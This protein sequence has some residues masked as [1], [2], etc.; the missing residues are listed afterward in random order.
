MGIDVK[1][2]SMG[3]K[4]NVKV[5][6]DDSCAKVGGKGAV[7]I[8]GEDGAIFMP[9]VS[10]DGTLTWTNDK[11]LPNPDPV[12][13]KGPKGDKGDTGERGPQGERGPEGPMGPQGP[14]GMQ[15]PQ[16]PRGLKGEKGERGEQGPRGEQ[17]IKGPEGPQGPRG[18]QGPKGE[19]GERGERGLTGAQG[20]KGSQGEQ[21]PRGDQGP[22]GERGP[23]GD[24]G[25][26]GKNGRDGRDGEDYILTEQDK[27]EIAQLVEIPESGLDA[28]IATDEEVI[29]ILLEEDMLPVV[30]DTDGAILSDENENILLW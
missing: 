19:Q 26:D 8:R 28:E 25:K 3:S 22:R 24:P 13:I 11:E 9:D 27:I 6:D 21:G 12:N 4:I 20:P 2:S 10:T 16:G 30:A 14:I 1:F 29:E 15:G 17:G 23:Q 18:A 7:Y 5:K